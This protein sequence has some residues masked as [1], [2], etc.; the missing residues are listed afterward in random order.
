[1]IQLRGLQLQLQHTSLEFA[2]QRTFNTFTISNMDA[3]LADVGD[4][5]ARLASIE[6]SPYYGGVM[7]AHELTEQLLAWVTTT[8]QVGREEEGGVKKEEGRGGR[9]EG[10]WKGGRGG[11]RGG[12]GGEGGER[13]EGGGAGS[14]FISR[15]MPFLLSF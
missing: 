5:R 13:G 7:Q 6:R 11:G 1:M 9:G 3:V 8:M 15:H 14:G 10:G 4:M 2:P 12:E